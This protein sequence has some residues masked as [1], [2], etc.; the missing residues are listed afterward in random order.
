MK[1][2]RRYIEIMLLLTCGLFVGCLEES[3]S[4]KLNGDG[5]SGFI[6]DSIRYLEDAEPSESPKLRSAVDLLINLSKQ[7]EYLKI[8]DILFSNGLS[9]AMNNKIVFEGM[10]NPDWEIVSI[11]ALNLKQYDNSAHLIARILDKSSDGAVHS[12]IAVIYF[13]LEENKWKIENFPFGASGVVVFDTPLAFS[14]SIWN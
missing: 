2:N 4:L 5:E 13:I 3:D 10:I 12:Q 1:I 7:K 11:E 8:W 6:T 14:K 9:K